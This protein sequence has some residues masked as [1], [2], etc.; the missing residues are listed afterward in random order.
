MNK[1]NVKAEEKIEILRDR[2]A[3]LIFTKP[4][5]A[6]RNHVNAIEQQ[7][8]YLEKMVAPKGKES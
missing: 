2:M 6:N 1:K 7:I 5:S 8:R 4:Y 3:K